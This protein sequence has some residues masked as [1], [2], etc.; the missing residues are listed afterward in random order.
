M[1]H[2]NGILCPDGTGYKKLEPLSLGA[3]SLQG[4]G[5]L[6]EDL[7]KPF[8]KLRA[9]LKQGRQ[10]RKGKRK[11][12]ADRQKAVDRAKSIMKS[13]G[14]VKE[15]FDEELKRQ[16]VK[17]LV[18]KEGLSKETM[19]KAAEI[20]KTPQ[21]SGSDV[22]AEEFVYEQAA[23]SDNTMLY[24]GIGAAILLLGGGLFFVN[25]KKT[26]KAISLKKS[27]PSAEPMQK[28]LNPRG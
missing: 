16:Q 6:A 11:A 28:L 26:K 25:K 5:M 23:Q 21:Q 17:S 12:K 14:S 27:I 15:A 8:E 24:V 22:I 13:S 9:N 18:A 7:G 10:K 3:I 1:N 2:Y 4:L 20:M 19:I